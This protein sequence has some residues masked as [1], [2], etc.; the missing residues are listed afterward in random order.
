MIAAPP[1]INLE[2]RKIGEVSVDSG[3]I[4]ISD[5]AYLPTRR[6]FDK[7]WQSRYAASE[8]SAVELALAERN[9]QPLP[10]L[11]PFEP[12]QINFSVGLV[13]FGGDG[14]YPVYGDFDG[15]RLAAVHIDFDP[16]A[17]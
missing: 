4:I 15:A 16:A 9:G 13:A 11:V 14:T 5:P 2:R 1:A 6:T 7:A 8:H 10:P 12:F 3:T 17:D